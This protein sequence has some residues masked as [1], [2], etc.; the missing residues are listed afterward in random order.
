[1]K[2]MQTMQTMFSGS[3]KQTKEK[4]SI[5]EVVSMKAEKVEAQPEPEPMNW[6]VFGEVTKPK[7]GVKPFFVKAT[8]SPQEKEKREVPKFIKFM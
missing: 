2:K 1:M 6:P 7:E 5:G 3:S 8:T 4:N